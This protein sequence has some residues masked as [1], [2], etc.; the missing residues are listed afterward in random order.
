MNLCIVKAYTADEFMHPAAEF[1]AFEVTKDL[2]CT[3]ESYCKQVSQMTIKPLSVHFSDCTPVFLTDKFVS[4]GKYTAQMDFEKLLDPIMARREDYVIIR[5]FPLSLWDRICN[6]EDDL[7]VDCM[8]M[9]IWGTTSPGN[10]SWMGYIKHTSIEVCTRD[11]KLSD[12]KKR[13]E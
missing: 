4:E 2:I 10:I 1:A 12:L 6:E 3:A 5:E 7:I 13:K 11:I 9:R 8:V